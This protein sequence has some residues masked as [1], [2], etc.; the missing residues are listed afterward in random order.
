MKHLYNLF[1]V[2]FGLLAVATALHVNEIYAYSPAL[3]VLLGASSP[4]FA[5]MTYASRRMAI[6]ESSRPVLPEVKGAR[7]ISGRL[8]IDR[9]RGCVVCSRC[10]STCDIEHLDCHIDRAT[11]MRCGAIAY[12]DFKELMK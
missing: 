1:A 4:F 8:Y 6:T 11:C 10:S 12:G 7:W 9:D 2:F 3:G 5:V